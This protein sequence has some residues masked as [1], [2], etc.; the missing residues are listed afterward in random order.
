MIQL[1]PLIGPI[2]RSKL[3]R[4]KE[5]VN[6]L[7]PDIQI[8]KGQIVTLGLRLLFGLYLE[9]YR[10]FHFISFLVGLE[11]IYLYHSNDIWVGFLIYLDERE[12]RVW[13]W[14]QE[15]VRAIISVLSSFTLSNIIVD[16]TVGSSWN[17]TCS[18]L[19][20]GFSLG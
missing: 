2:I 17:F 3:N 14:V 18:L 8:K 12:R 13:S 20:Y 10:D 1:M 7:N 11:I 19:T 4:V 9:L 5:E 16:P 6:E 15:Q